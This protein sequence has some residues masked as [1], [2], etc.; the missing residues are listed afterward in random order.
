MNQSLENLAYS[1]AVSNDTLEERAHEAITQI[2]GFPEECPSECKDALVSGYRRRYA[3]KNPAQVY[4]VIGGNYVLAT[5]EMQK[6]KKVE[7]V[8][9]G[10][11]YAFSFSTHEY[12]KLTQENPNLRKLVQSIREATQDYCS[13][14]F[15]DLKRCA[16]KLLRKDNGT[17]RQSLTFVDSVKKSLGDMEKSVKTKASRGDTTAKPE[18]FKL[19]LA[20]FWSTYNA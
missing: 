4:A 9:I 7:K 1:Q 17:Q 8:S 13:N 6:N 19:A 15:G 3:E 16:K 12:A 5:E 14:R 10:V 2:A 18:K 20:A 11:E